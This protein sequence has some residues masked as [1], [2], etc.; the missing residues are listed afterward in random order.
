MNNKE[1]FYWMHPE[2]IIEFNKNHGPDESLKT[3]KKAA[4]CVKK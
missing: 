1:G 2:V 3:I 4:A